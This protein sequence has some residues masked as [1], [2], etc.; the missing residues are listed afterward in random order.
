MTSPVR[1][2]RP[3]ESPAALLALLEDAFNRRDVDAYLAP[4]EDD[5][6]F[7]VPPEGS[8]RTR[9]R[10]DP[11]GPVGA[12]RAGA[13]VEHLVRADGRGGDGLALSYA[14]WVLLAAPD[15]GEP[16]HLIVRGA[17]VAR[18]RPDSSW[19]IVLEDPLSAS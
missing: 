13:R 3:A 19:G 17:M 4:Y 9:S 11:L 10:R 5:A 14:H 18:R 1:T 2:H 16:V 12:V 7:V 15:D 8:R 6:V